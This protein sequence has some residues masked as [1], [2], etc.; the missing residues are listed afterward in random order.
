MKALVT[1]SAGFIGGHLCDRLRVHGYTPVGYDLRDGDDVMD[2]ERLIARA[3]G[4]DAIFDCAGVLGTAETFADLERTVDVNIRGTL[5][6]LEVASALRIPL[7]YLSLK[8]T[9]HNPYMITKRAA[10]EFCQMYGEYHGLPVVVIRGLNAYGPGQHWGRVRKVVPTFIVQALQGEPLVVYGS[11]EQ[12]ADFVYVSDMAEVMVRALERACWGHVFDCGT[13]I[14]TSV[15]ELAG[16]VIELAGGSSRL[17]YAR[18]RQGEPQESAQVAETAP[19]RDLL[20]FVPDVPLREGMAA[21]VAWYRA[22][23]RE[24]EVAA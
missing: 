18:M 11:G 9:W 20:G 7:V 14:S 6:V 4:C 16:L 22:H 1:G 12:A 21:T 15:N 2:G 24:T 13:G 17:Q 23:W 8:Q 5:R 3:R 19:M 10:T